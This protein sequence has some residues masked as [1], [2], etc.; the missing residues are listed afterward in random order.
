M[1]YQ[2]VILRL[3]IDPT[4]ALFEY[5]IGFR[6]KLLGYLNSAWGHLHL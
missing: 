6:E 1:Q 5:S 2:L 3:Q 4:A